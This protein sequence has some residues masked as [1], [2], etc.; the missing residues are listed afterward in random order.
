MVAE[1]VGVFLDALTEMV[2]GVSTALIDIFDTLVYDPAT[3][4]TGIATWSLVFGGIA[5]VLGL[6]NRFTRA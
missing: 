2:A 5:L 6:I 3:G 4:L 1:I